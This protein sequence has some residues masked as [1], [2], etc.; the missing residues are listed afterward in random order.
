MYRDTSSV[1]CAPRE[2]THACSLGNTIGQRQLSFLK[3]VVRK[4]DLEHLVATGPVDGKRPH[5]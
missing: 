5:T 2:L 1:D 3:H 4:D